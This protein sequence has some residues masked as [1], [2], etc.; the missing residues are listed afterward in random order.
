MHRAKIS[1]EYEFGS[2]SPMQ[3]CVD[4][5]HISHYNLSDHS[6]T[7]GRW[8]HIPILLAQSLQP[9]VTRVAATCGVWLRRWV[10]QRRLSSSLLILSTKMMLFIVRML[11]W[12]RSSRCCEP[13][14]GI[15]S[16]TVCTVWTVSSVLCDICVWTLRSTECVNC[17]AA[18][19]CELKLFWNNFTVLFHMHFSI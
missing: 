16:K 8:C 17:N 7:F 4:S 5:S 15:D 10:N 3:F 9:A 1:A 6:I 11:L 18:V 12:L 2:Y 14:I 13:E 19:T